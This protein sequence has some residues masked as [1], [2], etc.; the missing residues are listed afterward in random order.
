[1]VTRYLEQQPAIHAVLTAKERGKDK[2]IDTLR[3][4][5]IICAEELFLSLHHFK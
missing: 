5:D 2:D 4:N 3:E 1:M